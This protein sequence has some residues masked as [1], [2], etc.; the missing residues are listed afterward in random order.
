MR[1]IKKSIKIITELTKN[2]QIK[3]RNI[4][5]S[6]PDDRSIYWYWDTNGNVAESDFV[7]YM[8]IN[9]HVICLNGRCSNLTKTVYKIRKKNG[10]DPEII[11]IYATKYGRK[12]INYD[13]IERLKNGVFDYK[14]KTVTM[15]YPNIVVLAYKKTDYG[16]SSEYLWQVVDLN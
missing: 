9:H 16:L 1:R 8:M 2:W 12:D 6:K 14:L 4:L 11:I 5:L 15:N 13:D 3:L 7:R 10:Y